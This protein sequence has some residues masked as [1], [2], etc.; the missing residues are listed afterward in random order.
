VNWFQQNMFQ[1][2]MF[3]FGICRIQVGEGVISNLLNQRVTM[4][5]AVRKTFGCESVNEVMNGLNIK[6]HQCGYF[7]RVGTKR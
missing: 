2:L 4:G 1:S 6:Y 7:A 3:T 5:W